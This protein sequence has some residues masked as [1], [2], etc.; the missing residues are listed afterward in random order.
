MIEII[1]NGEKQKIDVKG[2][3]R[4][5]DIFKILNLNQEEFLLIVDGKLTPL[6]AIIKSESKI[7]LLPVISG[8]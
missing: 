3:I 1:V 4:G 5:K 6:E 8:G 7:E 2:K